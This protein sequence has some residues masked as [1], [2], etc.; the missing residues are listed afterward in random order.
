AGPEE[1]EK[2][3]CIPVEEAVHT[4]PGIKRLDSEAREGE[5]LVTLQLK[6]DYSPQALIG[7]TRAR[8]Q[9]IRHLPKGLEKIER[10]EK[11]EAWE[12]INVMLYGP[13]DPLTLR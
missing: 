6:P 10:Q 11:N 12:S 9:E 8:I 13:T 5:C 1:I 7:A 4:L 3:L 2:A